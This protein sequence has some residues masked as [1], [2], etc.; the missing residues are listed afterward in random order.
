MYIYIYIYI[1]MH[2]YVIHNIYIYMFIYIYIYIQ[3]RCRANLPPCENVERQA[4]V[5]RRDDV[6]GVRW[7]GVER[8][9]NTNEHSI[10]Y[11]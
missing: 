4:D 6:G 9:S 7:L 3:M 5:E 10:P 2:A 8:F 11:R 1:Y